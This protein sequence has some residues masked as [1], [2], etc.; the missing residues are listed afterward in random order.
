MKY[1]CSMETV[2]QYNKM[3]V[4]HF[5]FDLIPLDNCTMFSQINLR[6]TPDIVCLSQFHLIESWCKN[7]RFY[8]SLFSRVKALPGVEVSYV[9]HTK[10]IL[11]SPGVQDVCVSRMIIL[12]RP[13]PN[14]YLSLQRKGGGLVPL[15]AWSLLLSFLFLV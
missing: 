3:T 14:I 2:Q 15:T 9:V 1:T 11:Q 13:N 10:K 4:L 5:F 6:W 8:I 12:Y 7:P